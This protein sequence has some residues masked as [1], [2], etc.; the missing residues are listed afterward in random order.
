MSVTDTAILHNQ[1]EDLVDV[2]RNMGILQQDQR[3]INRFVLASIIITQATNVGSGLDSTAYRLEL[4]KVYHIVCFF[5][6]NFCVLYC[7]LVSCD[8]VY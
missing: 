4:Y 7:S 5:C 6:M 3:N 1:G 2:A 8:Y